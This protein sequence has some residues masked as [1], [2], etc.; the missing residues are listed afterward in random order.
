MTGP[1]GSAAAGA[2]LPST[3]DQLAAALVA[4]YTDAERRLL[5]D[6]G[7]AARAG[8][9]R[10]LGEMRRQAVRVA[11]ALT[12]RS[13]ALSRD[14]TREAAQRGDAAALA[15]LRRMVEGDRRLA[16]IYLARFDD[17]TGHGAA[18]AT[19]IGL[20]LAAKVTGLQGGIL[21]SVDDAYRAAVAEAAARL[22]RGAEGLTPQT[23][24]T[25]AWRRLT[26]QGITGFQDRAGRQ[27][28]LASYVEMATRTAVQRAYN[29]AA[30]AR[31]GALGIEYFTVPHDGHPCPLC[32]PWEGSVLS[33]GRVGTVV[34][35]NAAT[36]AP[37]AFTVKATVDQARAA[38]LWH[39]NCRHVLLPYMPGVTKATPARPWS[40]T[41]Q[42][43]Y[44]ATQRL[45]DLE[46]RVRDA[47]RQAD[48]AAALGDE[49]QHR[50]AKARLRRYQAQIRDHVDQH[51]LV[52]RRQREQLNLGHK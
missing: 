2:G 21:R 47:K 51:G 52:R 40:R 23:A 15:T 5:A 16:S 7:N 33:H 22:T 6:V 18:A 46:R 35:S 14:I 13:A 26:A 36:G 38:G 32:R 44:D 10:L 1:T 39:P 24:Q 9:A 30:D 12:L 28:N 31:Y 42:D 34:D 29:A 48:L 41:D 37:V 20:E 8:E 3:V 17:V 50:Q 4:L 11:T 43:A 49:Q 19:Q 45:R 27:W 25:L